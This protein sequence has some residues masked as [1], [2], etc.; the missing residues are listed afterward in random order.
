M[1]ILADIYKQ[2][3]EDA[4]QNEIAW[5]G[6]VS[7]QAREL[8]ECN[9]TYIHNHARFGLNETELARWA[10][11][12]DLLKEFFD[13][14]CVT[15]MAGDR[16]FVTATGRRGPDGRL[17]GSSK[18]YDHA[19][20]TDIRDGMAQICTKPYAPFVD[21]SSGVIAG[22]GLALSCSGG[23]FQS[24]PLDELKPAFPVTGKFKFWGYG[25]RADGA[26]SI[27]RPV[28]AWSITSDLFY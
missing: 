12:A 18:M 14:A 3:I 7:D 22:H 25:P 11:A 6:S 24:V 1:T 21:L 13:R 17:D 2:A 4:I 27:V 26:L 8:I 19:L 20:I 23:Y 15:P 9:L 28:R 5:N 16:V 10:M